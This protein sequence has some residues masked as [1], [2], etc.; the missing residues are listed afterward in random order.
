MG[1]AQ[2]PGGKAIPCS[3]STRPADGVLSLGTLLPITGSTIFRSPALET[4]VQLAMDDIIKAGGIPGIAIK[5]DSA[6]QRDEG[7]PSTD[8][9]AIQSADALIS[10][11]VDVI[12]GPVA[13]AATAKVIDKVTCEGLIMFSSGNSAILFTAYP[14]RGLYFRTA[15]TA[16][17]EGSVLGKLVVADG[18]S[19]VVVMSRD[20]VYGNSLRA[21]TAKVI[22]ASGGRVLDS[23]HFDPNALDYGKEVQRV[24]RKSPDAIAVIGGIRILSSMIRA[25]LGPQNKKV[26]GSNANMSNTLASQLIPRSSGVLAG[27]KGTLVDTGD[28]MFV[29]RLRDANSTIRDLAYAAQTYDAVVITALAAA[30]AGTDEPVAV[31][32]EINGVTRD[33]EKC[34][35]FAACM[36]LVKEGKDIDYDGPSGSL[37]FTD[38]GEPRSATYVISECQADGTVKPLKSERVVANNP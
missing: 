10:N 9:A 12:I 21:A 11:E 31:S 38:S 34:T 22:E 28:E 29:K 4:S 32:K 18:N 24:K 1:Y 14:D 20:D 15:P 26:Y 8:D 7:E 17:M 5:L 27:M 37:E 3:P 35:N 16:E 19:T 36:T 2:G 13:S 30:V 23:F 33:G 25:G 6:N